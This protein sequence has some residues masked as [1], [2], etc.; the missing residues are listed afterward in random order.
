M[1]D[2]NLPTQE[3]K[4]PRKRVQRRKTFVTQPKVGFRDRI[5]GMTEADFMKNYYAR[6]RLLTV[7]IEIERANPDKH[8]VYLDMNALQ[9]SGFHHPGGYELYKAADD[10]ENQHNVK[11]NKA[12]DGYIHRN[13]MVLA[14]ISK[15]EQQMRELEYEIVRGKRRLE[16]IFENNEDLK[17]SKVYAKSNTQTLD[18][19]SKVD[20][21]ANL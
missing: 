20:A 1:S 18:F 11:F 17:A 8:F 9:K 6:R 10:P 14:Y 12:P 13:E 3:A 15:D 5:A 21:K 2:Q 16:D 4:T 7:P 19:K